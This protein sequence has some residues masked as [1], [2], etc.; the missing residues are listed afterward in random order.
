VSEPGSSLLLAADECDPLV[1]A[2]AK[3]FPHIR[4][5][6]HASLL[7]GLLERAS[8]CGANTVRERL[9]VPKGRVLQHKPP[10]GLANST[11]ALSLV[12]MASYPSR[13]VEIA[14]KSQFLLAGNHVGVLRIHVLRRRRD[15]LLLESSVQIRRV[16]KISV[17]AVQASGVTVALEHS[18]KAM[19]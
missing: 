1:A 9:V 8:G 2:T 6:V 11:P 16:G 12:A 3:T 17:V 15:L 18:E 13:G 4:V 7:L 10:S 5:S 19:R 14:F